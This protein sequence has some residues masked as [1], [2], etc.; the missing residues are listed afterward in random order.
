MEIIKFTVR[1]FDG[2]LELIPSGGVKDNSVYEIKFKN[3]Q[4]VDG[5]SITDTTKITT[6]LAPLYCDLESVRSLIGDMVIDDNTILYHIREASRFAQYVKGAIKIKEDSVPFEA[7][8]FTRYKAAHDCVLAYSVSIASNI[9]LK[10]SVGAVSFEQ[11]ETSRDI[12]KILD[13]LCKELK[14]WED[15]VKGYKLE[16]RAKMKSVIRGGQASPYFTP[17]GAKLD[18]GIVDNNE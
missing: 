8:M 5:Q 3:M 2:I 6:R 4:S 14:R 16:G 11:R 10:G 13:H 1:V 9:G 12:G 7:V 18:R 17:Y 15:E